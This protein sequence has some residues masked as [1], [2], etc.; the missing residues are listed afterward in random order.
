[1]KNKPR[2]PERRLPD[3]SMPLPNPPLIPED[4]PT[5]PCA[6][7]TEPEFVAMMN[8]H[9]IYNIARADFEKK[10]A[11]VTL[12]LLLCAKLESYSY[13]VQFNQQGGLIVTDYGSSPAQRTV[14]GE[15][16]SRTAFIR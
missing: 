8:A 6:A 14:I 16:D 15:G 1:M 10:R 4:V 11:A 12:K 2:V 3:Q 7:V 13:E 5:Q 9:H